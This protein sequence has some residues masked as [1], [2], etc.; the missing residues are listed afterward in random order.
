[1]LNNP[2]MAIPSAIYSLIMFATGGLFSIWT[3]RIPNQT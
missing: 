2:A 3:N 1:I